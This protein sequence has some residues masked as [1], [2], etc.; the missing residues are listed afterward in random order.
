MGGDSARVAP[1]LIAHQY[2]KNPQSASF[3]GLTLKTA[4]PVDLWRVF[5]GGVGRDS[6]GLTADFDLGE[7]GLSLAHGITVL[8][9][10]VLV[11]IQDR[12]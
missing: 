8:I 6:G 12:L 1:L 5:I 2:A 9:V 3:E 4:L 10:Q 7:S 11:F